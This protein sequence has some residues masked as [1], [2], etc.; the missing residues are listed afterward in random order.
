LSLLLGRGEPP[1]LA[2]LPRPLRKG[3]LLLL[4]ALLE[5]VPAVDVL[6]EERPRYDC[7]L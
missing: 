7:A 6:R 3:G 5:P 1:V 4:P 2:V